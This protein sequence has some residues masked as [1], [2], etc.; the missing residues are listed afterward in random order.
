MSTDTEKPQ[1]RVQPISY[2]M[3]EAALAL[4]ISERTLRTR[5][6][7][8]HDVPHFKMGER[9]LFPIDRLRAWA[10]LQPDSNL[11]PAEERE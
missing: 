7:L 3:S 2:S 4:G 8:G 10:N 1:W 11:Q 9:I 6:K 5:M